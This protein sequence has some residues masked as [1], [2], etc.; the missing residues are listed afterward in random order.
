M[1]FRAILYKIKERKEQMGAI[2]KD[3][4]FSLAGVKYVAGDISQTVLEKVENASVKVKLNSENI[5]GVML[6]IFEKQNEGNTAQELTGLGKG[7][8]KIKD[9][10]DSY[11]RALELLVELASLQTSFLTLDE[12]IKATN[13]RVN[14]IEHVIQP[15][16][17]NTISYIISELDEAEREEFYRMKKIQEKKK[18]ALKEKERNR[19]SF[20][21]SQEDEEAMNSG[22]L[23]PSSDDADI[24]FK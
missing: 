24:I 1:K 16:I 3:A 7:G 17:E 2:M 14:A 9:C 8:Q 6:P 21:A 12:V 22:F 18:I 10:R 23:Q 19:A 13:R 11:I 15:K 5:A 4:S 20:L